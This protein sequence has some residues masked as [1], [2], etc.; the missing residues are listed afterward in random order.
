MLEKP[1][2]VERMLE[3][4]A[5]N[6]QEILTNTALPNQLLFPRPLGVELPVRVVFFSERG[7]CWMQIELSQEISASKQEVVTRALTLLNSASYMGAWVLN[8]RRGKLYFKLSILTDGVLYTDAAI[9]RLVQTLTSTVTQTAP[10]LL[11]VALQDA[12]WDQVLG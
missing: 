8:S 10:S 1:L 2:S 7:L 9:T 6:E 5:Q 12:P 11:K 4:S 3:W